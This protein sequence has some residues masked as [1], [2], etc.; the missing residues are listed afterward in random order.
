MVDHAVDGGRKILAVEHLLALFVDDRSLRVH[1][2]VIFQHALTG[3]EVAAFDGLLRILNGIGEHSCVDRRILVN[4]EAVQHTHNALG[5]EQTHNIVLQRQEEAR[6]TGVSLTAGT[7]TEL[8]VD[9]AGLMALRADD[10]Q[11]ADCTHSVRFLVHIDLVPR[12]GL[13]VCRTRRK[14]LGIIRLCKGIC[15]GND[16][17]RQLLLTQLCQR[18]IFGVAAQHDIRTTAGHVGG[19]RH[20]AE[21]TRLRY[22]FRF[23]FMV[24]CVQDGMRHAL[25]LE[26]LG[27]QLGFFNGNCADQNRLS[28][29]MTFLDLTDDRAEFS[30]LCF[31]DRIV[32]VDT[33]DG[34]I[35]R[36]FNNIQFVNCRE[37]L[38]FC[39]R[40]TGHTG[41]FS[42]QTE[43]IL[44]SDRCQR[45]IL[46]CDR[47]AL[48]RFDC[49][50]Q[51]L[52][53]ASAVHQSAGEFIDD[54]DLSV[55][56]DIVYIA[57]HDAAG[58]HCLVDMVRQ[59]GVLDI[60]KVLHRE[61]LLRLGN[62]SGSQVCRA[63]F[64][65]YIVVAV[66]IVLL[67]FFIGRGKD[68]FLQ[69]GDE[70]IRHFIQLGRFLSLTGNNQRGS[71]LVN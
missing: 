64:F 55:L 23:L 13:L 36:N 16:L 68:L 67:L 22:D 63:S 54:D 48:F 65:V 25:A 19:D 24:L 71:R 70:E 52:I 34:L 49:L 43:E 66:Q 56:D 33:D 18:H 9:T 17:V 40:G 29:F 45:F 4:A 39:Q 5:A 6:F 60:R 28:F 20:C 42:V 14:D 8:I 11:A 1:H 47:Y 51:T 21:L 15:L 27:K 35:G 41:Q 37:F 44:E 7:A 26:Q 69:T 53:V 38:L 3:L 50:M 61:E 30:R 32:V 62:A 58:T 10:K 31:V 57:L 2:I 12:I 46:A 59:R